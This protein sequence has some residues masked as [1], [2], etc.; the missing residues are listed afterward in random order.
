MTTTPAIVW[1]E[2]DFGEFRREVLEQVPSGD[3]K[4]RI[5]ALLDLLANVTTELESK[6]SSVD[7]LRRIVFG[8]KTETRSRVFGDAGARSDESAEAKGPPANDDAGATAGGPGSTG[9]AGGADSAHEA[10]PRPKGHGRR[11]ALA[12]EN[13]EVRK[14]PHESLAPGDRCP[15]CEASN[16]AEVAPRMHVRFTGYAPVTPHVTALGALRCNTCGTVFVA[17]DPEGDEVEKYDAGARAVLAILAYGAG[18]P[19]YRLAGLQAALGHPLPASTQWDVVNG[20]ADIVVPV[21]DELRRQAAQAG[22]L[23]NDDTTAKILG[24]VPRRRPPQPGGAPRAEPTPPPAEQATTGDPPGEV[25]SMAESPAA[26]AAPE[27]P[28]TPNR[29]PKDPPKPPGDQAQRPKG[30]TGTFTSGIVSVLGDHKIALY[31]TGWKHCGERANDLLELR[32]PALPPPIQMCDALTRNV[33]KAFGTILGNC[34]AHGRRGFVDVAGR[35]PAQ[36]EHVLDEIALVYKYDEEARERRMSPE[37][38]LTWHQARSEPVMKR[39]AEWMRTEVAQKRIEPNSGLGQAI[40]YMEKHWAE[41]T[42]FLRVAGAPL[43]NNIVERALKKAVLRR[44]ASLFFRTPRG[45]YVADVFTSLIHT[46]ELNGVVPFQY[47][48]TLFEHPEEVAAHPADW[49][50]WNYTLAARSAAA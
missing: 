39:L 8:P 45:A 7:R 36:V 31:A 15:C 4:A 47:L 41:L 49:L 17:T 46:C 1:R 11:A 30:R 3:L 6:R 29:T 33:P 19:A 38:R 34:L 32:D 28:G 5:L 9:E 14:V 43:D 48:R 27:V 12:F 26:P 22:L 21:V 50:P 23:H 37:E 20:S 16:V 42:L 44:K 10:R 18:M 24:P 35:F 40:A 25:G 13:A 2:Q